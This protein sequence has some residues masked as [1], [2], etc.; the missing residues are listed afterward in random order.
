MKTTVLYFW[1]AFF[2]TKLK[3]ENKNRGSLLC[4]YRV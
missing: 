2:A 4:F 1:L 3:K